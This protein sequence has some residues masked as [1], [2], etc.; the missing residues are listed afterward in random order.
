[1][2]S[3]RIE[4]DFIFRAFENGADGVIVSGCK[5]GECHY[6]TGNDKAVDRV[7]MTQKL[8]AKLGM[9]P[10]RLQTTWLTAAEAR[11]FA[12]VMNEFYEEIKVLGPNPLNQGGA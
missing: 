7:E 11:K 4:P 12:T 10:D 5:L 3:G 6:K 9:K 1:M 8:M 2:C